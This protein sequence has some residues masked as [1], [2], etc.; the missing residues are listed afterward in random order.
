MQILAID[1]GTDTLPALALSREPAEPGL[2]ERPPRPPGKNVVTR[3]LLARAW[4]F[5][6]VIAAVLVMLGFFIA[7]RH[8]GWRLGDPTGVGTPLHLTYRR[9][10]T[11][12]WLGVVACQIGVAFA[13]RTEHAS[14]R[15]VG[16]FTNRYLLAAIGVEL[17]FAAGIIYL[18]VLHMVFGTAALPLRDVAIVVPFPFIVWGADELR[19]AVIRRRHGQFSEPPELLT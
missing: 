18:P 15:S 11:V 2:M 4:G 6:G 17:I 16:V 9:A 10:T 12:A 8:G 7:L 5:I 3:Q 19:R 13:A 1:L 14:L